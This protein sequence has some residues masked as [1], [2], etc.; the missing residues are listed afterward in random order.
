MYN[1]FYYILDGREEFELYITTVRYIK[2]LVAFDS[3]VIG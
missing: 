1:Y 3:E 2:K